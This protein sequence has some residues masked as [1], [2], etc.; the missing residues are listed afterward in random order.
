MAEERKKQ[1]KKTAD[2][3]EDSAIS[4]AWYL[5][6]WVCLMRLDEALF[7]RSMTP[8]RCMALYREFFKP[9]GTQRGG[10]DAAYREKQSSRPSLADYLRGGG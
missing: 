7:W 1:K 8:A 4:F 3:A 5:N 9:A 6:I 10:G 2:H